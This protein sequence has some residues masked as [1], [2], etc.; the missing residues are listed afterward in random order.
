MKPNELRIGNYLEMLGKVRKIE[1][2][3]NLPARKEMYW[4]TCENMIDT[5]IIH[6]SPILLTEKWLL[7]FGFEKIVYDSEE[8]GYGTDYHIKCDDDV[9]MS[10]TD[11]FSLG[12]YASKDRMKND[13]G[14]IPFWGN[15]KTVHGL[16][17]IYFALT[18]EE[19]TYENQTK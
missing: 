16:Q 7:K 1:C 17:N 3:S 15:T 19:L 6:F 9:F 5:K 12:L 18:G 2:I 11:D 14:V 4:L 10:Y 13:L 8:T